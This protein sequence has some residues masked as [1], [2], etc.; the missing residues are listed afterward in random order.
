MPILRAASRLLSVQAVGA[1][2]LAAAI[3]ALSMYTLLS[4][5]P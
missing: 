3:A 5:A 2:L 4:E 1:V